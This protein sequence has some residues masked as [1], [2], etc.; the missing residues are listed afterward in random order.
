MIYMS[1]NIKTEARQPVQYPISQHGEDILRWQCG[2][3]GFHVKLQ[4][5]IPG[6]AQ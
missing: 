4:R 2:Y 6:S 3:N 5:D 1:K